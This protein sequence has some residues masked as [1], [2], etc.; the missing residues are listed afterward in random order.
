MLKWKLISST[1]RGVISLKCV[2]VVAVEIEQELQLPIHL[3]TLG[4]N[5]QAQKQSVS[6]G[7]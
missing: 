3:L 2:A 5:L 7:I 6:M 1:M 4:P